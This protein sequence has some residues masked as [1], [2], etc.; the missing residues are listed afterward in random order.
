MPFD[1]LSFRSVVATVQSAR[2]VN[3]FSS[4]LLQEW[5]LFL[6]IYLKAIFYILIT[7]S[8][9]VISG[10]DNLVNQQFQCSLIKGWKARRNDRTLTNQDHCHLK[11]GYWKSELNKRNAALILRKWKKNLKKVFNKLKHVSVQNVP[12]Y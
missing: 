10:W 1:W 7:N 4:F 11:F 2:S 9:F 6:S 8:V 5:K 3:S 12:E